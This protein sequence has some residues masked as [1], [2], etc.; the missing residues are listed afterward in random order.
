MRAV[1]PAD[2]QSSGSRPRAGGS[3]RGLKMR[4]DQKTR[5]RIVR[6][7]P[8]RRRLWAGARQISALNQ[9]L[10]FP[11]ALSLGPRARPRGARPKKL[12]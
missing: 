6:P 9:H 10:R 7:G 11:G 2:P 12:S 4:A 5:R 8:R 1:T 3:R